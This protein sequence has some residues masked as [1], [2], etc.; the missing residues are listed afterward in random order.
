MSST[1]YW[2]VGAARPEL[3][4]HLRGTL[5]TALFE[6]PPDDADL[7][8][9]QVMDQ[10][11]L[12]APPGPGHTFPGLSRPAWRFAENLEAQR[13][14]PDS[15][16]ACMSAF[17]QIPRA[18]IYHVGVRKGDPVA[19]VYYGLGYRDARLLPGRFGCFLLTPSDLRTALAALE[20]LPDQ[21]AFGSAAL[22]QRTAAWLAATGDEPGLNPSEL[23]EGPLRIL[24]QAREQH[25]GAIGFMQW[26]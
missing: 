11:D 8:W 23:L 7:G 26:Y 22:G 19:A 15:R 14:D 3:V 20:H 18:A 21:P 4:D 5:P 2:L 12:L 24:R 1:G 25:L 9:W 17:E 10:A 13:P 16:D 6:P